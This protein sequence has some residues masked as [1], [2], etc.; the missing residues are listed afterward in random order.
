V[1]SRVGV[2]PDVITHGREGLLV[3]PRDVESLVRALRRLAENPMD[4]DRMARAGRALAEA[5]FAVAP[6]AAAI[7]AAIAAAVSPQRVE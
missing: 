2:V 4:M 7:E 1:V 5:R 3:E 6:A